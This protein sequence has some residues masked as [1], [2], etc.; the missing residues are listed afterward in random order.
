MEAFTK[1]DLS[2]AERDLDYAEKRASRLNTE[3]SDADKKYERTMGMSMSFLSSFTSDE[4]LDQLYK[5][6]QRVQEEESKA[7]DESANLGAKC[8]KIKA[9]L[10]QQPIIQSE[11]NGFFNC[12]LA[13]G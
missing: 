8:R 4:K 3:C 2:S 11:K 12:G 13:F 7:W 5:K 10:D 9:L 6:V 1:H